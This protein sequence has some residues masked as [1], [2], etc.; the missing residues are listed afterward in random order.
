M[1]TTDHR[2]VGSLTGVEIR[3]ILHSNQTGFHG[4]LTCVL[5]MV[6]GH[7]ASKAQLHTSISEN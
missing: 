2:K 6:V 1:E 7:K 3:G 5:K 4:Y